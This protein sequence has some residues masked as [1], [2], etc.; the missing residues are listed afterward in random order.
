M[1]QVANLGGMDREDVVETPASKISATNILRTEE[2][3]QLVPSLCQSGESELDM[4][5]YI[6]IT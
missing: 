6:H 5:G 3:L 4:H 1:C 2:L